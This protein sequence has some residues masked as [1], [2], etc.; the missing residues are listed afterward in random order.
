[1]SR[2]MEQV[3]NSEASALAMARQVLGSVKEMAMTA[4]QKAEI[5]ELIDQAV[6]KENAKDLAGAIKLLNQVKKKMEKLQKANVAKENLEQELNLKEQYEEQFQTLKEVGILQ[7]F[8]NGNWGIVDI[9]GNEQPIPSY[10][11]IK[12]RMEAKAEM[13]DKK[14]EQGFTQLLLVPIGMKLSEIAE[15]AGKLIIKKHKEGKL[16]GTDGAKLEIKLDENGKPQPVF[17]DEIYKDAD[18][19]GDLVYGVKKFDKDNHGGQTKSELL[20]GWLANRSSE[21][22][23]WQVMFIEDLP[24]LPEKGKGK[25]IEGRQ[26]FDAGQS[27]E[28]Y[29][30]KIQTEEQYAD[31]Q[32]TTPEAQ[33]IYLIQQL[34]HHDQMIDDWDGQG[35]GC[36]NAGAYFKG[37]GAVPFGLWVRDLHQ[38]YLAWRSPDA[39]YDLASVRA[40]VKF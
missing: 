40:S 20:S 33:L 19:N 12:K 32:F 27:P 25:D 8:K 6:A 18:I 1:M 17:V 36:W 9:L 22:V 3:K 34:Q 35:K 39:P 11:E 5:M 26:Q 28:Q 10:E 37:Q 14:R 31:E 16:L 29:L 38:F 15:K 24:D 7:E 30:A 21:S 13:L 4:E 2:K 23:G